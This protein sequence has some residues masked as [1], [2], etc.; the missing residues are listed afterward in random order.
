MSKTHIASTAVSYTS[1]LRITISLSSGKVEVLKAARV[2][3]RVMAPPPSPP[4]ENGAGYWF[5][6]RDKDGNLLY[7]RPL[8]HSDLSSIEVFDDPKGGTIRRVT[9]PESERKIDLII[10]DFPNAVEFTLHGPEPKVK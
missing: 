1:S 2:A 8:P 7:H 3:M 5:E 10:P 9:V 6:V 4:S